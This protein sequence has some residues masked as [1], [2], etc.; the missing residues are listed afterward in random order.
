[1][2]EPA[3]GELLAALRAVMADERRAIARLDAEAIEELTARKHETAE[4][5]AAACR[6]RRTPL[7]P[8]LERQ[9]AVVRAELGASTALIAAAK[10]AVA[11]ALGR[12]PPTSYDRCART[13]AVMR[14]LRVVAY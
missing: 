6:S 2:S 11:A 12:E 4:A 1:M 3:L 7:E 5:L 10:E 14:P 9:V 13:R 8:A